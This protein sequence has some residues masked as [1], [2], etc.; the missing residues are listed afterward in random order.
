[1][2][3]EDVPSYEAATARGVNVT[4]GLSPDGTRLGRWTAYFLNPADPDDDAAA[5]LRPGRDLA[6]S[7]GV[8]P[9]VFVAA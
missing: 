1:V 4:L 8:D 5:S 2:Y 7:W 6:A 9:D 3:N